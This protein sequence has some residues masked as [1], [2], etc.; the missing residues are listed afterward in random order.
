MNSLPSSPPEANKA[1]YAVAVNNSNSCF[2]ANLWICPECRLPLSASAE[3]YSCANCGFALTE[4][5]GIWSSDQSFVPD[6]FSHESR[7]HLHELETQHFW[8]KPRAR[9][10]EH[11]LLGR[12]RPR[13]KYAIE[14]GCG[15]GSFLP[16]LDRISDRIVGMEGHLPSLALARQSA[17]ASVTLLH[18]DVSR[19]PIQDGLFDLACAFDVVKAN[20]NPLKY[21]GKHNYTLPPAIIFCG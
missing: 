7:A 3:E 13:F 4:Q 11:I 15:N 5:A 20:Q 10:F 12:L 9:L 2:V 21:A 14:L 19:V 18:G 16:V 8:F 6:S 17:A 1:D